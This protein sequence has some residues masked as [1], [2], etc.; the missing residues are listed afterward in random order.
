MFIFPLVSSV[1]IVPT[2]FIEMHLAEQVQTKKNLNETAIRRENWR[3]ERM[4]KYVFEAVREANAGPVTLQYFKAQLHNEE[5]A[6]CFMETKGG[7]TEDLVDIRL[8]IFEEWESRLQDPDSP[9]LE[10]VLDEPSF[11]QGVFV[12]RNDNSSRSLWRSLTRLRLEMRQ[13]AFSHTVRLQEMENFLG[14]ELLSVHHD[15]QLAL[16]KASENCRMAGRSAC[17]ASRQAAQAVSA[18]TSGSEAVRE[19]VLARLEQ[20]ERVLA[21]HLEAVC[22]APPVKRR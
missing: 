3:E 19:A 1:S 15:V 9:D 7:Y 17:E 20:L 4:L 21:A 16:A 13:A 12:G 11:V 6:R 14:E 8:G 5:V 10:V 18:A 22:L 2:I